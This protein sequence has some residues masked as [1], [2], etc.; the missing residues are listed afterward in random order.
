MYGTQGTNFNAATTDSI[1]GNELETLTGASGITYASK[2]ALDEIEGLSSY[3]T[4]IEDLLDQSPEKATEDW[5]IR[6]QGLQDQGLRASKLGVFDSIP[7]RVL[8]TK[9]GISNFSVISALDPTDF[10]AQALDSL[11]TNLS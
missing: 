7:D 10:I 6:T 5:L 11:Y 4:Q 2:E 3:L 9:N 1:T 8:N